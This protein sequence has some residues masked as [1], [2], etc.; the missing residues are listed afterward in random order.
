MSLPWIRLYVEMLNDPK[1]RRLSAIE[2]WIWVGL[3]LLAGQAPV[4]G[5]LLITEG[6]LYSPDDLARA[7]D[8]R[9]D[10]QDALPEALAKLEQLRM[11]SRAPDGTIT[12]V[13]WEKRQRV[14]PSDTPA[15][16]RERKQRSRTR[17][18][19]NEEEVTPLS[20]PCPAQ[21]TPIDS[22]SDSESDSD[23]PPTPPQGDLP[24]PEPKTVI[25]QFT[26]YTGPQVLI[27]GEY[28]D[29]VRFTRRSGKVAPSV[30][31]R[32]MEY[33]ERFP[34]A[35]V[36]E[37][38]AIH[39]RKYADKPEDYTRGIVRRLDKERPARR[40]TGDRDPDDS[41]GMDEYIRRH[42]RERGIDDEQP[43]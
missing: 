4:R 6:V 24:P 28:W 10:E 18:I 41:D 9:H 21:V 13:N 11:I 38:L 43:A 20:R 36:V 34:A 17:Q 2:K 23:S 5:Q 30:I 27:I 29:T 22:D 16:W 8:L 32:E 39:V 25:S 14:K 33:W 31:Q 3:L 26:R 35:V 12:V 42:N 15:A 40:Q 7:L 19:T 37:A 1:M